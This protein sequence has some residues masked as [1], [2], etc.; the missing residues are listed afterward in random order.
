MTGADAAMA[1]V[2]T[3]SVA[4]RGREV[5]TSEWT[6]L[7]SVRSTMWSLLIAAATLIGGSLIMAF[8][9]AGDGERTFDPVASIYFAWLQYPV[10]ALGVLGVLTF[11]SEFSTGQIRATFTAVPRRRAVLAARPPS[12]ARS[13]CCLARSC[14]SPP[15][16]SARQSSRSTTAACRWPSPVPSGRSSPPGCASAPPPRSGWRSAPSSGTPRAA[17]WPCP[18]C[19]TSARAA[20]PPGTLGRRAGQIHPADGVIPTGLA[21]SPSRPPP[22]RRLPV[23]P[24]RV[25]RH[26]P[27]P[28]RRA[29]RQGHVTDNWPDQTSQTQALQPCSWTS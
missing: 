5:L 6:K 4:T 26:R 21:P 27:D 9:S 15:S 13:P 3:P 19:C 22:A 18:C 14:R 17:S 7:R 11:T 28:G 25:A 24:A 8:A 23:R 20:I 1:A 2:T 12:S 16:S 10:L 29:H